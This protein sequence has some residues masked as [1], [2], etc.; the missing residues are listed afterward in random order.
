MM[1]KTILLHKNNIE[2]YMVMENN[3]MYRYHIYEQEVEQRENLLKKASCK[4]KLSAEEHLWLETHAVYNCI[5]GVAFLNRAIENVSANKWISLKINI[6][7]ASFNGKIRPTISVPSGRGKIVPSPFAQVTDSY[8]KVVPQEK[9]QEGKIKM[10]TF[11]WEEHKKKTELGYWS[12]LGLLA[13]EYE[14]DY[15]DEK[16]RLQMRGVSSFDH[17]LA[18]RRQEVDDHTVRYYC[19]S[20]IADTFD[21]LIFSIQWNLRD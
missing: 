7:S 6:E 5:L 21:A 18:M 2:R 15:Y 8:G 4:Q 12:D 11:L 3:N 9:I 16:M 10:Y 1:K 17:C 13:V 19:K 20:P 14:C